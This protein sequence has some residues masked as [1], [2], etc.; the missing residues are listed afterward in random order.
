MS[1]SAV[2]AI[3]DYGEVGID[4]VVTLVFITGQVNFTDTVKRQVLN[5]IPAR[6]SVIDLIDIDILG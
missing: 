1:G 4:Q 5:K 2:V 6:I 3:A